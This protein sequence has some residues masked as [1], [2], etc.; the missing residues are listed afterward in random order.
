MVMFS[1]VIPEL[2]QQVLA[3]ILDLGFRARLYRVPQ[4]RDCTT[5]KYHVRLS[6]S[7]PAFL[8]LVRPLKQ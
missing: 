7:V 8:E 1:T 6:H 3:I 5:L 4:S 2:A